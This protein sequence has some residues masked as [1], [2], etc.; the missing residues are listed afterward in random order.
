VV[1][2]KTL[3]HQTL[4]TQIGDDKPRDDIGP[5]SAG[6]IARKDAELEDLRNAKRM[7]GIKVSELESE[8]EQLRQ[9]ATK[10]VSDEPLTVLIESLRQIISDAQQP[11]WLK[12]LNTRK[13]DQAKK[14][15]NR[16]QADLYELT[17]L[18][19]TAAKAMPDGLDIPGFLD[20]TKQRA[21]Q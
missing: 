14:L 8:N 5:A 1:D 15:I 9:Q 11:V 19:Q 2:S 7:L 3:V 16:L 20:R 12:L 21:A 18:R 4:P 17:E 6:E 13:Q 10:P